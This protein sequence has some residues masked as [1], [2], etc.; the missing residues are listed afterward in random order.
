MF[1]KQL[2]AELVLLSE[3]VGPSSS[4]PSTFFL[5]FYLTCHLAVISIPACRSGLVGE[6]EKD[7][8]CF[9]LYIILEAWLA[10]ILWTMDLSNK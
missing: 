1:K 7:A 9:Q 2:F 4:Q 3:S 6:C 8:F 10:A 5:L